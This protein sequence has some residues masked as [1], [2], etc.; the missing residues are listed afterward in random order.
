MPVPDL[1]GGVQRDGLRGDH[2]PTSHTLYFLCS[3]PFRPRMVENLGKV[4]HRSQRAGS[5]IKHTAHTRQSVKSQGQCVKVSSHWV[6]LLPPKC[7]AM[8]FPVAGNMVTAT[9]TQVYKAQSRIDFKNT[10]LTFCKQ[11]HRM[12]KG[13]V[14]AA[15]LGHQFR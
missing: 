9:D 12:H 6:T 15:F 4:V 2:S 11:A 1:G 7:N 13:G 8:V 5:S 3:L 10:W 14:Q